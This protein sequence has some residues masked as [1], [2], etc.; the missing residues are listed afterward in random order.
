[1]FDLLDE[2]TGP[3]VPVVLSINARIADGL[4]TSWLWDVPFERLAGRTVVVTGDRRLDLAV[5]LRYA[6]VGCTVVDGPLAAVDAALAPLDAADHSADGSADP[7][8]DPGEVTVV[9]NYTAF[10]DLRRVL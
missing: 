9:A 7:P 1:M 5:R 10:A 8:A 4:D 2:T 3:D 6:E